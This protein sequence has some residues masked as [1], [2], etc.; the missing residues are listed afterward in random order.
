M[1]RAVEHPLAPVVVG[2]IAAVAGTAA[3]AAVLRQACPGTGPGRLAA[4][5]WLFAAGMAANVAIGRMPFA[6]GLA[7]GVAAWLCAERARHGRR[8][9]PALAA[10]AA[11][12]CVW[13]S[14]VAGAFLLLAVLARVAAGGRARPGLWLAAPVLAGG[15]LLVALFP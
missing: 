5:G 8:S 4:A 6:L 14:P 12:P 7:L 11:L 2:V 3:F 10:V 1:R 13:A 15:G 9:L